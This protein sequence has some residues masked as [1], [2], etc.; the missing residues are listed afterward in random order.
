MSVDSQDRILVA[1]S[2]LF[3]DPFSHEFEIA[4]KTEDGWVIRSLREGMPFGGRDH[5]ALA[6]DSHGVYHVARFIYDD[7]VNDNLLIY[8]NSDVH[9]AMFESIKSAG[10]W[11]AIAA[12]IGWPTAF[13][14]TKWYSL[15]K[16]RQVRL[17]SVGLF[18]M[19]RRKNRRK[20]S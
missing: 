20:D 8:V 6:V 1:Y 4:E 15:R 2:S 10:L 19:R 5:P 16:Q 9:A 11:T 7:E 12:V 3:R 14:V 13:A 17:E 18:E